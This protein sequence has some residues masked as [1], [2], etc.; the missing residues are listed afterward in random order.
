MTTPDYDALARSLQPL[1]SRVRTD[2]TAVKREGR[3][4]WTRQELTQDRLRNHLN[5]GPAR[6]VSQIKAGESVTLVGVL[7]FDSHSGETPWTV[8]C[9]RVYEVVESLHLMGAAPLLFRSGG[10]RGIHVYCLWDEPQDA[11]SVR[12]FLRDAL[13]SCRLRDGTGGV[14]S[15]A[16]EVYPRQNE[17]APDGYG[18]QVVLPLAGASAPLAWEE[19]A[20]EYV[21]LPREAAIGMAWP[22]S[23]PVPRRERPVHVVRTV[24]AAELLGAGLG[25]L[26]SLLD[27]IP[28]AGKEELDYDRW[29]DVVFILHHET[30][31]SETGLALAHAFSAK[32]GKYDAEFLDSRVWPFIRSEGRER[33][34]GIGSLKRLAGAFG[35][36]APLSDAAFD[37][38]SEGDDRPPAPATLWLDQVEDTALS[39]AQRDIKNQIENK[40]TSAPPVPPHVVLAKVKRRGIPEARHLTTDQANANRLRAAFGGMVIVAAGRWYTW[41]GRQWVTDESDVYRYG[42]RLS[43]IIGDESKAW[44]GQGEALLASDPADAEG[45]RKLKIAEALGKWA[46]KSE[47]KGT[48]EAAIGLLRK[49]LTVDVSVLDRDPFAL[50][51]LNGVVDLRTGALRPHSADEFI[52]KL[53]PVRYDARA[54]CSTWDRAL[55]EI[56]GGRERVVAF[57]RRW[58]GYCLTGDT[59]EQCFVVHWGGGRNGKSTIL[60]MMAETMG[61]YADAA[62]PGLLVASRGERHPTEIASL[63]NKRMVTAHESGEAVV[64]REDFVKQ[65]TGG[66]KI[67]AR[68]MRED[69]FTFSPT[70]KIQLLTNHKPQV[71]GQDE[72]I[73]GRV[74]MLPYTESFGSEEEVQAGARTRV[75]DTALLDR[76][77]GEVEGVLAWRVRGAVEWFA[78]GLAP[79]EEV[80]AASSAYRMEQDRV[81]QFVAECCEIGVEWSEA[82]TD[83][84]GG[85]YPAYVSWCKD[86]GVFPL[87]KSRFKDE[88]SRVVVAVRFEDKYTSVAGGGRRKVHLVRGLRLLLE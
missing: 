79:P 63:F 23:D 50:N 44:R 2:V 80:K 15:G 48:I 38:V 49:M 35:W 30:G 85:L 17:V 12:A 75:R 68:F 13:T 1:I 62:P 39:I 54:V 65:A 24:N 73:W 67:S 7:D 87:S 27:A 88:V 76:L 46:G 53:V 55:S 60:D 25:E 58:F 56:M 51:C 84:M 10:G 33:V 41:N 19:L 11:F 61:D 29:R 42:C 43:Q 20:G 40:P 47:M 70:H 74:R 22:A 59:R 8:M 3:Q 36:H 52:T 78:G 64:L 16:V 21:V 14:A 31:G 81:G 82:L 77:R 69:F 18:N 37:D 45:K 66:D 34:R 4:A 71:K 28:N 57:A 26:Q 9:E 32:S 5:G 86:G 72:G 83:G 6:G